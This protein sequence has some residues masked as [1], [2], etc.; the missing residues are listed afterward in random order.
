MRVKLT[1]S[2]LRSYAARA[3]AYTVGDAVCPGLCV[4]VTPKGVKTF[5]FAY[6]NK[7]SGKV[8]WLTLGRYPEDRQAR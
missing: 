8:E 3:K 7:A 5:A 6:R 2:A 1:D 4:R